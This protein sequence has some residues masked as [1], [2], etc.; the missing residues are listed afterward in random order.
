M[1]MN[2]LYFICII[3]L[4]NSM[5]SYALG[6]LDTFFIFLREIIAVGFIYFPV[7]KASTSLLSYSYLSVYGLLLLSNAFG[8]II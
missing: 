1:C 4:S 3:E 8:A 2:N 6:F 5:P 7:F